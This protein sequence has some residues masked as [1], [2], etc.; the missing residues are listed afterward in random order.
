MELNKRLLEHP[1]YQSWSKGT[2]TMDQLAKYSKSYADF[3][4]LMPSY[5]ERITT[6]LNANTEDSLK[7]INEEKSHI[8]LWSQWSDLLPATDTY[9]KMTELLNAFELMSPSELLGAVHAFE[10]QQPEVAVTKKE[11]LL[12]YYG[13]NESDLNY[14]DEHVNEQDH[15]DFG[16]KLKPMANQQEFING[17]NV[18]QELIYSGLDLFVDC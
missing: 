1:F 18:G 11:G 14:F 2:V 7:I 17:F 4:E 3:I 6:G 13:Y 5:W 15:I 10:I 16:D 12:K 9:P 8:E